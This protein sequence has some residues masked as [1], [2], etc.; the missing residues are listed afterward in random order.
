METT[1][2]DVLH[3]LVE[4]APNL[5]EEGKAIFHQVIDDHFPAPADVSR[6][7]APETPAETPETPPAPPAGLTFRQAPDT[8]TPNLTGH[9]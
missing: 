9:F 1:I 5:Y 3:F 2:A 4:H 7:T 6:E 8:D